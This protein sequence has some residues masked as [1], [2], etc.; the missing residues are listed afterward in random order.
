[1]KRKTEECSDRFIA[2]TKPPTEEG[3]CIVEQW[4]SYIQHDANMDG[5]L[6]PK[7]HFGTRFQ[8]DDGSSAVNQCEDDPDKFVIATTGLDVF[9]MHS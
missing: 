1:M 8:L 6:P 9:R 2:N 4:D 5:R 7:E 3:I